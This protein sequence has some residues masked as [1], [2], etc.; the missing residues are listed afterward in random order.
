MPRK[1]GGEQ[2]VAVDPRRYM[3]LDT[4]SLY[5]RAYFGVP[6]TITAPDGTPVNAVRGLLEFI[7]RLFRDYSPNQVAAC[8][9]DDWRPQF[10]VDLLPEYKA[11]RVA[12]DSDEEEVPDALSPQVEIIAQVLDA[13]GITRVGAPGFEADDVIGTLTHAASG[14]VRIVT[15]DRDLFQLVNDK[16]E[17]AVVYTASRGVSRAELVD[18]AYIH[19]R[20]GIPAGTYLDY[21]ILRGDPSD[22][23]PGV[24]GVGER[25]AAALIN[26]FGDL[27]QVEAAARDPQSSL[28]P[29]VRAKLLAATDYLARARDVV[30]VV[31]SVPLPKSLRLDVPHS[32]ADP[33][34]L[35][36][37]GQRWGLQT[38]LDR[39][40][41]VLAKM[42]R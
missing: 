35:A 24:V 15:G 21:S 22:G 29:A 28:R 27:N 2:E 13:V 20:Y 16:R 19:T 1:I 3:L 30:A 11:T 4:A 31:T 9:D 6:D 42:E 33:E 8:W 12:A 32:P 25:T 10:R 38:P 34:R 26:E 41:D 40:L 17:I 18:D 36:D 23:L 7:T 5:F 14:P 37:L 39:L